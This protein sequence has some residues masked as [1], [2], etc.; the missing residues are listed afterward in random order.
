MSFLFGS[1]S[2]SQS[3]T[4]TSTETN[5]TENVDN[6]NVQ[7][8]GLGITKNAGDVTLIST[9][10]DAGAIQA[11]Q[12]VAAGAI[13]ANGDLSHLVADS[14]S[15]VTDTALELATNSVRGNAQLVG[16]VIA[17]SQDLFSGFADR[18]QT[19]EL[20]SQTQLG[21]TVAALNGIASQNNASSDQRV[22]DISTL[23]LKLAAAAVVL[24]V[25]FTSMKRS[26]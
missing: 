4:S 19:Y 18:L 22:Q 24:I 9:T 26:A 17:S 2:D 1:S 21:N 20:N 15:H 14:L 5:A 11:V 23:G 6:F 7:D 25:I 10:I 13:T 8:Q 12:D 16:D 3:S